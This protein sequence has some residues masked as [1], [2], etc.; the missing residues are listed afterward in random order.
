MQS[1]LKG[2][3]PMRKLMEYSLSA[4][5]LTG[6]TV[7]AAEPENVKPVKPRLASPQFVP[8]AEFEQ[9]FA[10]LAE[11][12]RG[13][14]VAKVDP[15]MKI[16]KSEKCDGYTRH[17]VSYNVEADERIEGFLLVPDDLKPGEK[18]PLVLCL[19]GTNIYGK[20]AAVNDYSNPAYKPAD[21]DE[22]QKRKN[23]AFA[24]D[25]VKR[26]LI[27]FAPDRAGFGK[28]CPI[29]PAN[30][31]PGMKEYEKQFA[32]AHPGWSY[33]HG[34]AIHD[35]SQ[36]L[37]FLVA[38]PEVDA[39]NIGTIGHSLGGRDSIELIAFEPR[40]KAAVM[41]CGGALQY[42]PEL[43]TSADA[44]REYLNGKELNRQADNMNFFIQS[45]A[46]RPLLVLMA[47]NDYLTDYPV[48]LL[49]AMRPIRK[50]YDAQLGN[51]KAL[52][53]QGLFAVLAHTNGHDAPYE[54]RTAA[55]EWLERQLTGKIK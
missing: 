42:R 51:P 44:Q 28:R 45:A 9:N 1:T 40:V 54:V 26:G 19:H 39:A 13:Q 34:K 37:D 14:G 12:L 11:K 20:D 24:Y 3:R 15:A 43:W 30:G 33:N 38:L 18:R 32:A 10:A 21:A 47:L 6:T 52:E 16:E 7:F 4:L 27:T 5:L 29:Q 25:L 48:N 22:T 36:A 31:I 2:V 50:Y 8:R 41:S 46:P 49:D 23:R 35:L 17:T 53:K 55:Y